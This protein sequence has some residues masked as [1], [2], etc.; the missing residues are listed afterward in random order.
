MTRPFQWTSTTIYRHPSNDWTSGQT[1]R[2]FVPG[3]ICYRTLNEIT[4]NKLSRMCNSIMSMGKLN[5]RSHLHVGIVWRNS[6]IRQFSKFQF[7]CLHF[8]FCWN[9]ER[10]DSQRSTGHSRSL[11]HVRLW[12]NEMALGRQ[13]GNWTRKLF[14]IRAKRRKS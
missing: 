5:S 7:P 2:P 9:R 11:P 12:R 13:G 14:H 8:L 1:F 6:S 3:H 4:E 10:L